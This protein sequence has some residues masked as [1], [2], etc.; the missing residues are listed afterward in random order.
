MCYF[1]HARRDQRLGEG[2]VVFRIYFITLLLTSLPL[3]IHARGHKHL[4]NIKG[5]QNINEQ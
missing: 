1:V 4:Q 3:V 2:V 5:A